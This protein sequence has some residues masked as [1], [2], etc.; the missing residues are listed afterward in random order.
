MDKH[1][2]DMVKKVSAVNLAFAVVVASIV[3]LS[4]KNYGLFILIGMFIAIF[5][6]ILNSLIGG[7]IF[8]KLPNSSGSLY[9]I[10]FIVRIVVAAGIGY[11]IFIYNKNNVIAYLFGYTS[12]LLGVY[13]YSVI[14]NNRDNVT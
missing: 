3:Q 8:K 10:C 4:F 14:E 1:I 13:I 7:M 2:L 11:A 5:N 9:I 6:F 12:H